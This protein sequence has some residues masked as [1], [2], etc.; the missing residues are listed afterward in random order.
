MI[1]CANG[2]EC[3]PSE[4]RD[5]LQRGGDFLVLDVRASSEVA[6]AALPYPYI[7]IPLDELSARVGELASWREK[8]VIVLCHHGGRSAVAQC[9]LSKN[10]FKNVRNLRGGINAYAQKADPSIPRY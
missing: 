7:H 1:A 2:G 9:F 4:L 8:E 3:G 5:K 6:T 10:G